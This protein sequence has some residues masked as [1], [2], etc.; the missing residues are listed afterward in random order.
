MGSW[1]IV[2]EIRRECEGCAAIIRPGIVAMTDEIIGRDTPQCPEC[3]KSLDWRL[4]IAWAS[5]P[6]YGALDRITEPS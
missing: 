6:G 4:A 5:I 3:L 1:L 2:S